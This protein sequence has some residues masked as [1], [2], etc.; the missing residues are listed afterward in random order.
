MKLK[1]IDPQLVKIPEVRVTAVY[2]DETEA[3]LKASLKAAGTL[4]PIVVVKVNEDYLLSDGLHRLQE[5]K[6]N[7]EKTVPAVVYEGEAKDALLM[8]LCLNKLRGKTKASEMVNVIGALYRDYGE[9]VDKVQGWTGYPRDYIEKLI[10]ISQA[11]PELQDALDKELIGV[12]KAFEIARLPAFIQQD[13]VVA[14]CKLYNFTV[15]E[16]HELVDKTLEEMELL[17]K[18]PPV[19]PSERERGPRLYVCE[20]CKHDVETRYIR[21]VM[22]CPDCFGSVWR[23]AKAAFPYEGKGDEEGDTP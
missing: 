17:R 22:L 11:S 23:L 13:E 6:A 20:G 18:A 19:V 21:P 10:M 16:L 7:G 5:A 9:N 4:N 12:G 8:N 15:K 1:Y 3:I 14:K 2:D